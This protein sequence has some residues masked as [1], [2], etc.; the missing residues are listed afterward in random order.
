[1]TM[2][3]I[4]RDCDIEW[5]AVLKAWD[6]CRIGEILEEKYKFRGISKYPNFG[7]QAIK[8]NTV[9]DKFLFLLEWQ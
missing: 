7:W 4:I 8:F 6:N 5:C 3:N 9:E 2:N 1:M